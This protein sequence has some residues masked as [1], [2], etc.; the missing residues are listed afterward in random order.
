MTKQDE[1]SQ[2]GL[3]NDTQHDKIP[4]GLF[5]L[6]VHRDGTP[7]V[8]VEGFLHKVGTDFTKGGAL[9]DALL[10][11]PLY[12]DKKTAARYA[13]LMLDDV[14][15]GQLLDGEELKP[16]PVDEVFGL[17]FSMEDGKIRAALVTWSDA[18][19]LKTYIKGRITKCKEAVAEF[20]EAAKAA[21]R[22]IREEELKIAK[23]QKRLRP[24]K[25][26]KKKAKRV[27]RVKKKGYRS[28]PKAASRRKNVRSRRG[29]GRRR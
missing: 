5:V 28:K 15:P 11:A 21:E 4:K 9:R 8:F 23:W 22:G 6:G 27:T 26:A 14:T 18:V 24:A 1:E 10:K 2:L 3:L 16:I 29:K 25:P 19:P 13:G 7:F 12:H 17:A 20:R